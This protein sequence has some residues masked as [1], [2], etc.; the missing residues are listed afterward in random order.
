MTLVKLVSV[1]GLKSRSVR[2]ERYRGER[3]TCQQGGLFWPLRR[4]DKFD[5]EVD[6]QIG[7]QA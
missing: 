6:R 1:K 3:E 2:P 7:S 4:R 5:D